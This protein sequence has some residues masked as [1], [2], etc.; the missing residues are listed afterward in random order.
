MR[1][2]LCLAL[3]LAFAQ[4]SQAYYFYVKECRSPVDPGSRIV[5]E[6]EN[7][8]LLSATYV[9]QADTDAEHGTAIREA[10]LTYLNDGAAVR[11]KTKDYTC[12]YLK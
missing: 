7:G 9:G 1:T 4:D 3:L 12:E 2:L 8:T 11:F 5:L 10:E 6:V